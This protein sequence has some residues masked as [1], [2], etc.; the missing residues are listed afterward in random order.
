MPNQIANVRD[1]LKSLESTTPSS[2]KLP[3]NGGDL[4]AMGVK[5]GPVF[6]K[7]LSAVTE[8]WYEDPE[9][10]K[11]TALHIAKSIVNSQPKTK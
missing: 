4:I 2:P 9:I 3:I 11:S 6:S 10:S 1:R 5:P 8:K 7:I